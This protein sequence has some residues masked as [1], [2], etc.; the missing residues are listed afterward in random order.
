MPKWPCDPSGGVFGI[1]R[2]EPRPDASLKLF[3]DAGGNAAVNINSGSG[4]SGHGLRLPLQKMKLFASQTAHA[5]GERNKEPNAGG[6]AVKD[7]RSGGHQPAQTKAWRSAEG[8]EGA[9]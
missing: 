9:A 7:D 8:W 2:F 3:N 6:S 5:F 1:P 4:G